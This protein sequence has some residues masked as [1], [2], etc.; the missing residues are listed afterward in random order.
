MLSDEDKRE[1]EFYRSRGLPYPKAILEKS[2]TDCNQ[3]VTDVV[4]VTCNFHKSDEQVGVELLSLDEKQMA[5]L[6]EPFLRCSSQTTIKHLKKFLATKFFNEIE[7]QRDV[8]TSIPLYQQL[9]NY[10]PLSGG[11]SLQ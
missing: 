8:I 10:C 7:R 9:L 3:N 1:K 6:R 5:Q 11:Y 2:Q 4:E